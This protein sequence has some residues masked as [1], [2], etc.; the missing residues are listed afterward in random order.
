MCTHREAV[1][2]K[3]RPHLLA[4]RSLTGAIAALGRG[5]EGTAA[6]GMGTSGWMLT[7]DRGSSTGTDTTGSAQNESVMGCSEGCCD[8]I[9]PAIAHPRAQ[10]TSS[11]RLG[12]LGRRG[13]GLGLLDGSLLLHSGSL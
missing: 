11:S 12:C 7:L 9:L 2:T 10:R 3:Q 8:D 1:F 6:G 4:Q 5:S 13:S